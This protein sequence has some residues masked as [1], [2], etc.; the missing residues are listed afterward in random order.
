MSAAEIRGLEV[1]SDSVFVLTVAP[2]IPAG[3]WDMEPELGEP[4]SVT[5]TN[6]SLRRR[7]FRSAGRLLELGEET[8]VALLS[9]GN[10]IGHDCTWSG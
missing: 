7:T 3:G 9:G 1:V 10:I 6:I 8:I 5:V 2:L 4:V